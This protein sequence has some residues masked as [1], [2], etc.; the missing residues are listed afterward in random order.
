MWSAL[1]NPDPDVIEV[2][3]IVNAEFGTVTGDFGGVVTDRCYA[4]A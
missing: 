1:Q 2:F 4:L 3:G